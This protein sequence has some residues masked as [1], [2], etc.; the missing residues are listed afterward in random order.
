[1]NTLDGVYTQILSVAIPSNSS[2][3]ILSDFT[4]SSVPLYFFETHFPFSPLLSYFRQTLMMSRVP[5][6]TSNLSSFSGSLKTHLAFTTN[7]S[8]ISLQMQ[9]TVY[10]T[11]DSTSRL[12]YNMLV[13]HGTAF[14]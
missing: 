2:P 11:P 9:N 5:W 7:H 12:E 13:L 14:E 8:Q 10:M 6:F 4:L 3:E 1:M